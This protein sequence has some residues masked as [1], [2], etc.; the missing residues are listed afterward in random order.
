MNQRPEKRISSAW[1]PEF[2]RKGSF[3]DKNASKSDF[4]RAQRNLTDPDTSGR[5]PGPGLG[6]K[7]F[8]KLKMPGLENEDSLLSRHGCYPPRQVPVDPLR[9]PWQ[10]TLDTC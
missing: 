5:F 3:F 10:T 6:P 9:V 1:R 2:R 4:E 7:N 8:K